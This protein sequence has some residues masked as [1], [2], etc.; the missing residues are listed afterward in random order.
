VFAPTIL[1][2]KFRICEKNTDELLP[3][4]Q[5]LLTQKRPFNSV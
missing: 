5:Y 3:W 4:Q 1:F 2:R